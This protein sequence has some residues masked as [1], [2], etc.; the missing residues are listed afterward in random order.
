MRKCVRARGGFDAPLGGFL[1]ATETHQGHC[2]G[3][4]HAEEHRI[5]GAQ[6]ARVVRRG[7]GRLR[8]AGRRV[9]EGKIVVGEGEVRAEIDRPLELAERLIVARAQP[10]RSAH[11]PVRGR[12][13]VVCHEALLGEVVCPLDFRIALRPA[14]ESVLP[15]GEGKTGIS[16]REGRVQAQRH[17]E[18]WRACSLS[19]LSNRYMCQRPRWYASQAS[20]EFG[21]FRMARLRSSVSISPAI[22]ATMLSPISLRIRKAS[23]RVRSKRSV[24]TIRLVRVSVSSTS[25]MRRLP[26][27]RTDPLAR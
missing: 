23:S 24:Q 7:D 2:P 27:R 20:R 19:A 26:A 13:T 17:F 10:E 6:A 5:E 9:D 1:E 18:K 12:V 25:T 11:R 15:M 16:A 8:I 22:A 3:A 4:E 21:G 14:L